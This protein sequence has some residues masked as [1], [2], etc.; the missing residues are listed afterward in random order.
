MAMIYEITNGGAPEIHS[1]LHAGICPLSRPERYIDHV[2]ILLVLCWN[3]HPVALHYQEMNL[4]YVKL[5]VFQ[6]SIFNGPIFNCSLRGDYGWGIVGTEHSGSR[7]VH[8][9]E[10]VCGTVGVVGVGQNLRKV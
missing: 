1:H 5:M 9:D 7:P 3:G 10:E 6:R 4:V 8:R 2:L